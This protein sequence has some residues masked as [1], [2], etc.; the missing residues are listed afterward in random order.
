[1]SSDDTRYDMARS[2]QAVVGMYRP[3]R[4]G[5]TSVE[6]V[7]RV[8]AEI[9]SGLFPGEPATLKPWKRAGRIVYRWRDNKGH[10]QLSKPFRWE[11]MCSHLHETGAYIPE[12]FNLPTPM[13]WLDQSVEMSMPF[14]APAVELIDR[15]L[16]FMLPASFGDAFPVT[17]L[18]DREGRAFSSLQLVLL[19]MINDVKGRLVTESEGLFRS[20]G[21]L[22][23]LFVYLN[24]VVS[25]VDN[26]L[27][28]LYYRA[29]HDAA[30]F[31]WSF[32]AQRL[33]VPHQ[34]RLSKKLRWVNQITGRPLSGCN[35]ERERFIFI[36]DVRNHIN[37]SNPPVF[38]FTIE[39]AADWLNCATDVAWL[40]VGIRRCM[41]EP[42]CL[43][44]VRMMLAPNVEW[45][46]SDP[47]KRRV[48][49]GPT[50]GYA[51]SRF[52][53]VDRTE[54]TG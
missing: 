27:H 6:Q 12:S 42:L 49:Q 11:D 45:T 4:F 2:G 14:H 23:D 54:R 10:V 47:G 3:L 26:T 40:L 17:P 21:W 18:L 13:S 1:V 15:A 38:A 19:D 8:A 31:S 28:Q 33:G 44:L 52:P 43:P 50:V 37:H 53:R 51:S 5:V 25:V 36:K 22:R 32:D 48:P 9:L 16:T 46:P 24:T 30:T 39:D 20:S 35:R 41:R 7:R 29:K 34:G